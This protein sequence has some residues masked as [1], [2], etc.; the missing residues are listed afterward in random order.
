MR[1]MAGLGPSD[2]AAAAIG[3]R[4]PSMRACTTTLHGLGLEPTAALGVPPR[5]DLEPSPRPSV[6]APAPAR[7]PSTSTAPR[8][9][10]P[11]SWSPPPAQATTYASPLATP[12]ARGVVESRVLEWMTPVAVLLALVAILAVG[13]AIGRL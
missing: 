1:T 12:V 2:F 3:T 7:L 10:P 11:R 9:P 6:P 13:F 8:Q 5:V 4:R